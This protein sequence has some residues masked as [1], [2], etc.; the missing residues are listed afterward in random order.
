MKET[1]HSTQETSQFIGESSMDTPS[2]MFAKAPPPLQLA[3]APLQMVDD[4]NDPTREETM[5]TNASLRRNN[6]GQRG[7]VHITR[8]YRQLVRRFRNALR[9]LTT[10]ADLERVVREHAA[11]LWNHATTE[12]RDNNDTGDDRPV[13]VARLQMSALL[14]EHA[15]LQ[16]N[17]ALL[18]RLLGELENHSRGRDASQV[19]F[20]I[21]AGREE[22]TEGKTIRRVLISGFDPFFSAGGNLPVSNPSGAV[23][24]QLDGT[25]VSS[26]NSVALIEAVTFP[27]RYED[28]DEGV[29][30]A[31]FR[32][33][34]TGENPVDMVIT[35]S[36][37]PGNNTEFDIE[38]YATR[39]RSGGD[40]NNGIGRGDAEFQDGPTTHGQDAPQF[41]ATRLPW[42]QMILGTQDNPDAFEV[43]LD[44]TFS[45]SN[46]DPATL[47]LARETQAVQQAVSRTGISVNELLQ[48]LFRFLTG[49]TTAADQAYASQIS[50]LSEQIQR[51]FESNYDSHLSRV[52]ANRS[53]EDYHVEGG[54]PTDQTMTRGSG[55]GYLSNEI[56]YR[57]GHLASD[58]GSQVPYGHIHIPNNFD[59]NGDFVLS[60]NVAIKDK[61][62]EIIGAGLAGL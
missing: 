28:F 58:T 29:V 32:P 51:E 16:D 25:M 30:E 33:H 57:V 21:P 39:H 46:V 56:M 19:R 31:L 1:E 52:Q 6:A 45:M 60:Q 24:M 18:T 14:R 40:D 53:E 61:V 37:D 41:V 44:S 42:Y 26:G 54:L 62:E 3:A 8:P 11:N 50:Q 47:E 15:A 7:M 55:G 2:G 59:Q 9:G 5:T 22:E 12:I 13:Y 4:E 36:L 10:E 34:M 38:A 20:E 48:M 43:R 27:V 49:G 35:L 23:A 17:E